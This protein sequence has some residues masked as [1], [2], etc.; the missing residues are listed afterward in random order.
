[1][2]YQFFF[3]PLIFLSIFSYYLLVNKNFK[4][5][6]KNLVY[7]INYLEITKNYSN[8]V[9]FYLISINQN[10][11]YDFCTDKITE[12]HKDQYGLI[13]KCSK[14][15]NNENL[16]Y[17]LGNSHTANFI[18]AANNLENINFSYKH[19]AN[20]F[21]L[22]NVKYLN[23]QINNFEKVIFVTSISNNVQ[24]GK[25]LNF[26]KN[27]DK[28]VEILLIGPIPFVANFD[29]L[30]CLIR[31]DNCTINVEED[32]KSRNLNK[33]I[34]RLLKLDHEKNIKVFL[35][36]N[37]LC[38]KYEKNCSIYNKDKDILTHRDGGHLTAE[39]S[40]LLLEPLNDFI[41]KNY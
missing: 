36:Y 1:M 39:G 11:I 26:Y 23:E 2:Y 14:I 25:F 30:K 18:T 35:P 38:N 3:I 41:N 17:F 5:V 21:D 37:Y 31:N 24:L 4:D 28:K 32:Y 9:N 19:K 7:K 10:K 20:P 27:L 22:E 12:S 6:V 33:L 40:L 34:M 8:R 16:F 29:P 13:E 15:Y